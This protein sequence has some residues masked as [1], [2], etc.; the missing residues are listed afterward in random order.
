[1][2]VLGFGSHKDN[3]ITWRRRGRGRFFWGRRRRFGRCRFWSESTGKEVGKEAR[4]C[5]APDP[6]EVDSSG[7]ENTNLDLVLGTCHGEVVF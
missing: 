7:I 2:A 4:A 1:M 5:L 6:R 3:L